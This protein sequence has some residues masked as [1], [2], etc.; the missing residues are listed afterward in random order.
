MKGAAVVLIDD[1]LHVAA[2]RFYTEGSGSD[3]YAVTVEPVTDGA[4][5]PLVDELRST[6]D[7]RRDPW[8]AFA[9]ATGAVVADR[10]RQLADRLKADAATLDRLN[11]ETAPGR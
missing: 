7:P 2:V 3:P 6:I 9:Q 11:D 8:A 4:S 1:A 5:N 10:G